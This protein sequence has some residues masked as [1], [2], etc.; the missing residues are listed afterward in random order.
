MAIGEA[1]SITTISPGENDPI[2]VTFAEALTDPVIVLSSTANGADPFTLRVVDQDIDGT[3][4]QPRSPSSSRNGN[5]WMGPTPP[6]RPSAGLP[7]KK[8]FTPFQTAG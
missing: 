3:A 8:V 4:T 6:V 5:T 1:G 7:S 2:T